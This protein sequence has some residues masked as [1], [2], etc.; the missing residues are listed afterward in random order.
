MG[1]HSDFRK[2]SKYAIE[3][4]EH[5]P[6]LARQ[7]QEGEAKAKAAL[8]AYVAPKRERE[9]DLSWMSDSWMA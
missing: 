2:D 5:W 9:S 1:R 7:N 6:T 8:K 3:V 4:R